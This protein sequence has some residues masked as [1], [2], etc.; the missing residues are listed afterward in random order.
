MTYD[1]NNLWVNVSGSFVD[2]RIPTCYQLFIELYYVPYTFVS[3]L[4]LT[5]SMDLLTVFQSSPPR[6]SLI[7]S[8]VRVL[9]SLQ[10][11]AEIYLKCAFAFIMLR[12]LA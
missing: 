11:L 8:A 4:L 3:S 10:A 12:V 1:C 6:A 9:P 2:V 5:G 7:L